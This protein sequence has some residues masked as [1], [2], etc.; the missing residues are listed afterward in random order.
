MSLSWW[1][2]KKD[3]INKL[4]RQP[5]YYPITPIED[6]PPAS[7]L[8]F[9][10][11]QPLTEKEGRVKGFPYKLPP[12]HVS[13]YLGS[14]EHL[15]QGKRAVIRHL[16]YDMRSTR[17]IDAVVYNA[18]TIEDREMLC[19]EARRRKGW[20]Y[21][22]GGFA[23]FGLKF[24]KEWSRANFCSEQSCE[25]FASKGFRISDKEPSKSEP[26]RIWQ[27]AMNY[28]TPAQIEM[29]TVHV[30]SEFPS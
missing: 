15:N 16:A 2:L 29:R 5:I 25:I 20:I 14:G 24:I 17:R 21:D 12:F 22:G 3:P 26:F 27:Y 1:I 8:L 28:A 4:P 23:S 19:R 9:Y 13:F 6:I 10:N 11:G 18:L 7:V 30:G